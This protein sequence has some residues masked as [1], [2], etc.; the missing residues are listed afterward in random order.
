MYS[1]KAPRL[2]IIVPVYKVEAYLSR[3]VDSILNQTFSD[4]E[5]LLID[6]GSPDACGLIC[7][8]YAEKDKRVRV[9]HKENG[10]VSSARNL[11]L[12]NSCAEYLTFCDSDDYME[13]DW[14]EKLCNAADSSSADLLCADACIVDTNGRLIRRDKCR[15]GSICF[16]TC[17]QR[18]EFLISYFLNGGNTGSVWKNVFR[19][20][21]IRK[22]G[23]RFC[24]TCGNYAEDLCF[25]LEYV[26]CS[27]TFVAQDIIGYNYVQHEGSMM[28]GGAHYP[29][30]N[31]V[32]EISKQFGKRFISMCTDD[33]EK[34]MMSVIHYM[35]M[36]PEYHKIV[37]E[38]L[39]NS[40]VK[41]LKKIKDRSWCREHTRSAFKHYSLFCRMLGKNEAKRA[42]VY[43]VMALCCLEL[44]V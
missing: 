35:I 15:K 43:S 21:I 29:K 28:S 40:F 42:V 33:A 6:D 1:L 9:F 4:F 22:N 13:P 32:N 18:A 41:E 14:L 25:I 44:T 8:E 27:S 30:F 36:R 23:I 19:T 3:C 37:R 10:G 2:S 7:D 20:E 38:K 17:Y 26:L 12:D 39:W 5:L 31:E 16:E 24:E 11:G 34:G